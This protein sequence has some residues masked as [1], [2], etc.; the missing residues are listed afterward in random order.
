MSKD[1]QIF[2][3]DLKKGEHYRNSVGKEI[4]LFKIS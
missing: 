2:G 1:Y 4:A 3:H